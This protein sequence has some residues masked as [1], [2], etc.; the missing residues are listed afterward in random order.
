MMK[1]T[2]HTLTLTP[3]DIRDAVLH[4]MK[5]RNIQQPDCGCEPECVYIDGVPM[6]DNCTFSW[7]SR[8]MDED[9]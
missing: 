8:E 2:E 1:K 9:L 4:L 3:T 6:I 7:V 5:S